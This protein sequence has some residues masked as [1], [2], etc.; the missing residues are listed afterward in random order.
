MSNKNPSVPPDVLRYLRGM[1]PESRQFDFFIGDWDVDATKF[2]PDGSVWFQYKARWLAQYL[3]DGR[4]VMDEFKA[5]APNGQQISS[6]VTVRT[7]CEI[8]SR[9]EMTGLAA[10]QPAP[11]AE[12]NGIWSNG[13]MQLDAVGID[14][15]GTRARTRI[16]FFNIEAQRFAWESRSSTDDGKTWSL[17]AALTAN[18][19]L[20]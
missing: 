5:F 11:N 20:R 10:F 9:W 18:R 4:I 12:W 3:D 17:G 2:Q 15:Q 19:A 6:Y 13:E 8:T 1:T 7:F 14:P 16:R